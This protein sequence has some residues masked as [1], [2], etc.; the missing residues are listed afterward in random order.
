MPHHTDADI[1]VRLFDALRKS[2]FGMLGLIDS[3]QQFPQPMTTFLEEGEET[4]WFY[5]REDTDLARAVANGEA[6]GLYVFVDKKQEVFASIV[7]Q[8]TLTRDTDR[9]RRFWNPVVAAWYPEGRDDP[10]LTL[11]RFDPS[12]AQVWVSS[13]GPAKFAWEI[14]K[15]NATRT[16]PDIGDQADLKLGAVAS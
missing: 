8:L 1:R 16:E 14:A 4:L 12:H 13:A 10:K 11:L 7:G 3:D 15:A 2:D 9:I 5:T 6:G